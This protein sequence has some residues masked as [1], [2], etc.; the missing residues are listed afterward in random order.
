MKKPNRYFLAIWCSFFSLCLGMTAVAQRVQDPL[1]KK[2]EQII[3]PDPG[4]QRSRNVRD[5]IRVEDSVPANAIRVNVRYRK[6]YGYRG[7]TNAFGDVGPTSSDAF[8]VNV[9]AGDGLS[10]PGEYLISIASDGTMKGVGDDY[11]CSYLISELPL[12][13]TIRVSVSLSGGRGLATETW[14]GGSAA[15]PPQGQQRAIVDGK[16]TVTLTESQPRATLVFEMVYA[17]LPLKLPNQPVPQPRRFPVP[18]PGG[19]ATPQVR[20]GGD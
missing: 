18:S 17:P 6:E 11:V 3:I 1:K 12:N 10:R 7:D 20:R 9:V 15:T 14:K 2:E 5:K 16:R 19:A 8:S 4:K 13:K